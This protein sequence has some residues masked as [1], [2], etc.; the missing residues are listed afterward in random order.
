M[1]KASFAAFDPKRIVGSPY[2]QL[3]DQA[4]IAHCHPFRR[5]R[6]LHGFKPPSIHCLNLAIRLSGH[7]LSGGIVFVDSRKNILAACLRTSSNFDRSNPAMLF[8]CSTSRL[9]KSGRMSFVNRGAGLASLLLG[10]FDDPRFRRGLVTR[11]TAI[12][13]SPGLVLRRPLPRSLACRFSCRRKGCQSC[14]PSFPPSSGVR[15]SAAPVFVGLLP[16]PGE[17]PPDPRTLRGQHQRPLA[18]K[19]LACLRAAKEAA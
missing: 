4:V 13:S 3:I 9:S 10:S 17:W 2:V 5:R 11:R 1:L 12:T 19:R 6:R 15:L 18:I 14:R 16:G 7:G 8:I